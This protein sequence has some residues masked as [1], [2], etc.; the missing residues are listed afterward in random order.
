ML[1]SHRSVNLHS[2]L[3]QVNTEGVLMVMNQ[4]FLIISL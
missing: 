4:L 2:D 1:L 3:A